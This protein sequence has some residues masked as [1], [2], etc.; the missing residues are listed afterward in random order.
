LRIDPE[1]APRMEL[2][3]HP[4]AS[5]SSAMV[6]P[7]GRR[8]IAMMVRSLLGRERGPASPASRAASAADGR[9]LVRLVFL[10]CSSWISAFLLSG[11]GGICRTTGS[12]I[13]HAPR[14]S[15]AA[16]PQDGYSNAPFLA[17]VEWKTALAAHKP[18][19]H[20]PQRC[21]ARRNALCARR[22]SENAEVQ[23]KLSISSTLSVETRQIC[24]ISGWTGPFHLY[25]IIS[26]T[27]PFCASSSTDGY[28]ITLLESSGLWP[29]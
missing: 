9:G 22:R 11:Y 21:I 1:I 16:Q 29:A 3:F 13:R 6:A 20:A 5:E 2:G 12:P 18:S 25:G 15:T 23:R 4:V 8:S 24:I 7:S 28:N 17:D 27:T 26:V 14:G 19:D 10:P